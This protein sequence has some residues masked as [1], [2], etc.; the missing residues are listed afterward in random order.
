M[1]CG[2]HGPSMAA[3]GYDLYYLNVMAGTVREWNF[4]D[5]PEHAWIRDSWADQDDRTR[6]ADDV[7]EETR[8]ETHGGAGADPLPDRPVQR[9]RRRRAAADPGLLRDLRP[10]QRRGR[11]AG[12]ARAAGRDAVLPR[13]QRAGA[14][15][16]PRPRTRARRTGCRRSRARRRSARARP[17][18]SPARR[19][20]R[21]TGCRCCCSPGD[22]F[23]TRAPGHGAAG[24]RGP[25]APT[26]SRSTTRCGRSRS[27]GRGSSVPSSSSRALLAA[28][29]VL[30]DPAETGAVT[31]ALPQDVQ[32]E[33]YDFPDELF[34][35]RVWRV[36]RPLPEPDV[37]AEA[38]A[39][40]RG[41]SNPLI[42]SRRRHDLRRGDRRAARVRRG[43][44]DRRG[45]D[46]G[47]QGLAA[48][49]P[50]AGAR[51][52]RRAP[53]RPP[54]TPRRAR[55]TWCS[56]S[57]RA[58]ATSRPRRARCSPTTPCSSTSTSRP[59]TRS[60]TPRCRWSPTRGS[61]S[62]RSTRRWT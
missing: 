53:A 22:V 36:R 62:R 5:D 50:S 28:M 44:R 27:S 7:G 32:A 21:S 4:V 19:W 47:G 20:R 2:Y 11:R 34:E 58:G 45:G 35:R 26:R 49:R 29:R 24:A 54:P 12:A 8:N 48:L 56:A 42:V 52:D 41:A 43:D 40:I 3:P 46:A 33:A 1:P 23:A 37:V 9:A 14:W 16:T 57:A 51:R 60:S 38:A 61:G 17:T 59:S 6:A 18:W 15:C 13:P 30:T 31:L 10:R 39:L 55:P 25:D